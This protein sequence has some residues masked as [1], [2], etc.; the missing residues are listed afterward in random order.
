VVPQDDPNSVGKMLSTITDDQSRSVEYALDHYG[1]L[2][3]ART[4]RSFDG[5]G[6]LVSY[7]K[8]RYLLDGETTWSSSHRW[9]GQVKN[10][11]H[12][13]NMYGYWMSTTLHQND[14]T[15]S[16]T[17]NRLTNAI[18]DNTGL[19]R[20]EQ[21]GYD[22]LSRLTSVNYGDGQQ[23]SYGFDHMGNRLSKR[24]NVTGNET[25]V[26]DNANRLTSRNGGAYT[27]DLNGNT[28]TGGGRTNTCL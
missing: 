25:S 1:F 11:W 15:Y 16:A 2:R 5:G 12:S 7:Q 3:E 9:L 28:L 27:N 20:T 13:K 26:F 22:E 23:Q 19:L 4:N 18:S 6:S 17:G 21:Y 24:D 10:T 8:A 14:Y